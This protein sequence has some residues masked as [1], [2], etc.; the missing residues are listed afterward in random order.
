MAIVF[1]LAAWLVLAFVAGEVFLVVIGVAEATTLGVSAVFALLLVFLVSVMTA[2][3]FVDRHALQSLLAVFGAHPPRRSGE[4]WGCR[5]C[6]APLPDDGA[7]LVRCVFCQGDNVTGVNLRPAAAKLAREATRLEQVL[8]RRR[9]KRRWGIFWFWV[10]APGAVLCGLVAAFFV[11]LGLEFLGERDRCS[12]GEARACVSLA[13]TYSDEANL[14][15][16]L[17]KA[18][19]LAE[20][21][22]VLGD[23]T[24]CCIARRAR[25]ERWGDF[26]DE[27]ALQ[28]RLAE[29]ASVLDAEC[30]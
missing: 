7:A 23:D 9:S 10:L 22:C 26:S 12:K 13:F 18:A 6:G 14:R 4:P 5:A 11:A 15:R 25:E 30:W 2:R 8:D 28:R 27:G 17:A 19:R 24:G 1:V 3:R 21:G 16:D 29:R 20:R